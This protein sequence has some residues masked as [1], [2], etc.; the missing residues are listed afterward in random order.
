MLFAGYKGE[1]MRYERRGMFL[2]AAAAGLIALIGADSAWSQGRGRGGGGR[3]QGPP[4][5]AQMQRQ[6][7][8]VERPQPQPRQMMPQRQQ[9]PQRQVMQQRPQPQMRPQ[10]QPQQIRQQ[11]QPRFE[12]PQTQARQPQPR[13]ERPQMQRQIPVRPPQAERPQMQRQQQPQ[14]IIRQQQQAERPWFDRSQ[15]RQQRQIQGQPQQQAVPMNRGGLGVP[16]GSGIGAANGRGIGNRADA[17]AGR[18]QEMRGERFSRMNMMQ[19]PDREVSRRGQDP[20]VERTMRGGPDLNRRWTQNGNAVTDIPPNYGQLR[21]R[22][23]HERN[24]DR[25][26]RFVPAPFARQWGQQ[27][28]F[29]RQYSD[30]A[31]RRGDLQA[32]RR[33]ERWRENVLRNVVVNVWASSPS[34]YDNFYPQNSPVYYG[35]SYY[36]PGYYASSYQPHY[37]ATDYNGYPQYQMF[38]AEP[39]YPVTYDAMYSPD[40]YSYAADPYSYFT[41][42]W[43]GN[44]YL[45]QTYGQ[46]ITLGYEEGL[47]DGLAARTAGYEE[48]YFVDPYVYEEEIYDPYSVS[49]GE[50]RRCLSDGYSLGY[51][52]ALNNEADHVPYEASQMD[53]VS[54]FISNSLAIL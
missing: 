3:P 32:F 33:T 54:I 10:Q 47:A 52:D 6:T 53:V 22:E 18:R 26:G 24:A 4:T 2:T 44:D 39:Y 28:Y 27:Q 43:T 51:Y 48:E 29:D 49:L 14:Q 16:N 13:I 46:L 12:R 8:R 35:Q 7:P 15:V 11:P 19:R 21:S 45:R 42:R 41:D 17:G 34:Y 1:D 40:Y 5:G 20:G 38:S 31:D 9:M 30:A 25:Q 50:N 37:Y 23:V 36:D